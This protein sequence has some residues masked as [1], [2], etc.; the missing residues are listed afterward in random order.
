[1]KKRN[2]VLIAIMIIMVIILGGIFGAY[3]YINKIKNVKLQG[4]DE[5]LKVSQETQEKSKRENIENILSL[6][7]SR[8]DNFYFK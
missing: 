4:S 8:G 7:G 6:W 3:K 5:E 1:M 2:K